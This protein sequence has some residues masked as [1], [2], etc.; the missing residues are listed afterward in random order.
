VLPPQINWLDLVVK[1]CLPLNKP[2]PLVWVWLALHK[3]CTASTPQW[4][5]VFL[6]QIQRLCLLVLKEQPLEVLPRP[7]ESECK[8]QSWQQ[9]LMA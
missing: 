3:T 7:V 6:K 5:T 8:E 1:I 2:L 9:H 4:F